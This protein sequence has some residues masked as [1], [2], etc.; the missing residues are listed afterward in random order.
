MIMSTRTERLAVKPL[1]I[2]DTDTLN[3]V[4]KT[5]GRTLPSAA[6]LGEERAA[7]ILGPVPP[8]PGPKETS[9]DREPAHGPWRDRPVPLS[10]SE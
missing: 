10:G 5:S 8:G 3:K 4:T 9:G 6:Y 2:R 1:R 7:L